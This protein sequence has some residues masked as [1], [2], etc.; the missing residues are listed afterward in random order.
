MLALWLAWI[1]TGFAEGAGWASL[2]GGVFLGAVILAGGVWSLR[3]ERLPGWVV[4]LTVGAALLRL[5][6]GVLWFVG[7][8]VWG[9]DTEVQ[10]AGYVMADAFQ[11]DRAAWD[12][13]QSDKPLT[14]AFSGYRAAD[15]YGGLLFLSAAVYRF[16]G[17]EMHQPLLMVTWTAAISALAVP[18]TWAFARRLFDDETAKW[19]A[20]GVALYPEAI[21]LGS[22]QMREAFMMTFAAVAFYG[23]ARYREPPSRSDDFSRSRSTTEV[24]TTGQSMSGWGFMLAALIMTLP[25]SPPLAVILLVLL[26]MV[27]LGMDDWRVIRN[28]Q[29]WAVLGGAALVAVI[30]IALGWE[31]I[32]AM[33][34]AERFETP[35]EMVA[36]WV[37]ISARW[38][39]KMTR[40]GSGVLQSVFNR[41]PEWVHLPFLLA[42]GVA[43]PLLPAELLY[44]TTPM[45]WAIGVWRSVGWTVLLGLLVYAPVR[46]IRAREKRNLL[47]GLSLAA[48]A[49]VG[50]ATFWGGGDQWDN[51]RYRVAFCGVQIVL[52][53]WA[54][55][56][57]RRAPDAW[58]RR[59][60]AGVAILLAWFLPWYLDRYTDFD[61]IV[62]LRA[63]GV[64]ESLGLGVVTW[65]VYVAWDVWR[66][67]GG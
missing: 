45:W 12:L 29:L 46:A 22:S 26:G 49:N 41:T 53:A 4:G 21:L 39:A 8:P 54:A 19:A 60:V 24:V 67:R 23:L 66:G 35:W 62:G 57:Y 63:P 1:S 65:V 38:Q 37:E 48:W 14:R 31:R 30:S 64:L 61:V 6:A 56:A 51:P 43:R 59:T 9:H 13:A 27:G 55:A 2:M 11:R 25:L 47:I 52:A 16:L 34:S 10:Q 20:W 32:A 5:G 50:I 18:F 42:Y 3:A 33:V 40:D 44:S 36:Y 58:M 28:W 7:L 17:G 15:Q